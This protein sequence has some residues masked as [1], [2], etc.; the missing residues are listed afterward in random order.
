MTSTPISISCDD[1][2]LEGTNACDDCLVTYLLGPADGPS[3]RQAV[4][5][6]VM[7]ARAM[8]MLH[9]VGLVPELR[10]ARRVG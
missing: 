5:V 6:D 2:S 1:C 7:E 8:R 3:E 4:I 10:F 9:E